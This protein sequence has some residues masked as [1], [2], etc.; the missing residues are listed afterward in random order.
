MQGCKFSDFFT[1]TSLK[2]I[3]EI[4][5]LEYLSCDFIK[6]SDF[7]E[8]FLHI[9]PLNSTYIPAYVVKINYEYGPL[10]NLLT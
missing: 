4:L 10:I 2:I 6:D 3:S 1:F 9:F 7:P 8:M 5:I